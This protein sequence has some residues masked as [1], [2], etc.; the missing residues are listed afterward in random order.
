ME[1]GFSH[2]RRDHGIPIHPP[3]SCWIANPLQ[4]KNVLRSG[5]ELKLVRTYY[6]VLVNPS[7]EHQLM[8]SQKPEARSQKPEARSQKPEARSHR[9]LT[10]VF[11]LLFGA[12]CVQAQRPGAA[13]SIRGV[14]RPT[15]PAAN[16]DVT[17]TVNVT[18]AAASTVF[19]YWEIWDPTANNNAGAFIRTGQGSNIALPAGGF[20]FNTS[21]LYMAGSSGK[22]VRATMEIQRNNTAVPG[23]TISANPIVCPGR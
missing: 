19:V 13:E 12:L 11:S 3:N 6:V 15:V 7:M 20:N 8:L 16:C 17:L 18:L 22:Y 21:N 5:L 4:P 14:M 9:F 1:T 23:Q 2:Q 10:I